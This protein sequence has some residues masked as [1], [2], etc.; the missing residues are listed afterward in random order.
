MVKTEVKSGDNNCQHT[1]TRQ[2]KE[3]IQVLVRVCTKCGQ[4]E[5]ICEN[6][7]IDELTAK[8]IAKKVN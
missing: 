8:K 6:Q 1:Y 4:E 3:T 5:V 2:S 7:H